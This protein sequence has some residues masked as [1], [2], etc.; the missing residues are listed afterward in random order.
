MAKMGADTISDLEQRVLLDVE[1]QKV[2][3]TKWDP[4]GKTWF[5][6]RPARARENAARAALFAR[7]AIERQEDGGMVREI[8][9]WPTELPMTEAYLAVVESNMKF[10]RRVY[11]PESQELLRVDEIKL[12]RR[13]MSRAEFEEAYG[14]LDDELQAEL[15]DAIHRI[16]PR[17][18]IGGEAE[19]EKN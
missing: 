7:Q 5:L 2:A 18:R 9:D 1:P 14:R 11:D 15:R 8:I 4:S 3:M 17:W 13:G 12:F 19:I 16:N 10:G 6:L